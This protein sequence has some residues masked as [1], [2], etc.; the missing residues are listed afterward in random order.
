[1][2][3]LIL[4]IFVFSIKIFAAQTIAYWRF[5]EGTNGWAN[6]HYQQNWYYDSSDNGNFLQT[7]NA[8]T[9]P[10]YTNK[11]PFGE[12]LKTG[13]LNSLALKFTPNDDLYSSGVGINFYNFSAG[14]TVEAMV[15]FYDTN[16]Y[17]VVV[18]K[19]GQP[20]AGMTENP[21]YPIFSIK[22][23]KYNGKLRLDFIDGN[24]NHHYLES[25]I[26]IS[27]HTWYYIAAICN[28]NYAELYIKRPGEKY[29]LQDRV[30]GISGGALFY[31]NQAWTVGRGKWNG[32]NSDWASAYIDEVRISNGALATTN[33]LGCDNVS[34]KL[35][36][37]TEIFVTDS[38]ANARV[39]VKYSA[40][41]VNILAA[42]AGGQKPLFFFREN[43]SSEFV[44]H[45]LENPYN[46]NN[47]D[48]S[49]AMRVGTDGK[50]RIA[51]CGPGGAPDRDHLLLGT[52]G[53]AGFS[54]QEVGASN[55]WANQMGFCL[56]QNNK[57]YIALKHQPTGRCA[58]FDNVS[59]SWQVNYFSKIDPN[60]PRA[61]LAVD[62]ANNAWLI[63]N[64]RHGNTNYIELWSNTGGSWAFVD[65]LTNAPSGNYEGCYFLQS[66]AGFE[67]KPDGAAAFAMKPDWWS[68]KLEVW[69]GNPIPEPRVTSILFLFSILL[70]QFCKDKI[71]SSSFRPETSNHCTNKQTF[72]QNLHNKRVI[73]H[74][75]TTLSN[76]GTLIAKYITIDLY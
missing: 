68:S 44:Q 45:S 12:V 37:S 29:E 2:K 49:F 64:G 34:D 56:D 24:T 70:L 48:K 21:W 36:W 9:S 40:G 20:R 11:I 46:P 65:Y 30:T 22:H 13:A 5:E 72:E 26:I 66:I 23:L 39:D 3:K 7:W 14:W 51:I 62:N 69:Q 60:Y 74:P 8:D 54:W 75:Y 43:E 42:A 71:G 27:P 15:N 47:G 59:G 50:L 53:A 58:V 16:S 28:G 57:A 38:L 6:D 63:F 35:N 52:E 4:L 10:L 25:S 73:R 76:I 17:Q 18:G 41:K 55:H 19:D 61:A 1:M 67:F 33:F 32:W 31:E